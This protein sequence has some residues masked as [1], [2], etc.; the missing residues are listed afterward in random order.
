M[1]N[2]NMHVQHDFDYPSDRVWEMLE[3]FGDLGWCVGIE[4]TELSGSGPGMVRSI[5]MPGMSA[6]IEEVL[7]SMDAT[8]RT[9]SYSIPRGNPMPVTNYLAT[10]RVEDLGAR[11]CRVHWSATGD[12]NGM[13]GEE[14]SAI[15][16]GVYAQMLGWLGDALAR[17]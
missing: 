8:A 17:G 11:R 9:F 16:G 7:E 6:P 2:V 1:S 3:N 4:R 10:V 5:H 13:S 14:V 12:A 15:L